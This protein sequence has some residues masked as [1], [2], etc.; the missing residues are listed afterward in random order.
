MI[1]IKVENTGFIYEYLGGLAVLHETDKTKENY[2]SDLVVRRALNQG[3]PCIYCDCGKGGRRPA[4]E[5]RLCFLGRH[6]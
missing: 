1:S 6:P 3:L 2:L 4:F 5:H